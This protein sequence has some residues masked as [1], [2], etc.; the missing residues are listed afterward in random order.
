MCRDQNFV[1]CDQML[2]ELELDR[3]EVHTL[4]GFLMVTRGIAVRLPYR[5]TLFVQIRTILEK[6]ETPERVQTLLQRLQGP[7]SES[8]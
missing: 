8:L 5:N 6:T 4:V 2:R 3:L 1:A 7:V